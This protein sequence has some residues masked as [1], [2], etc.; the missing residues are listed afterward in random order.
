MSNRIRFRAQAL[1]MAVRTW[2]AG[3]VL[4]GCLPSYDVVDGTTS[5]PNNTNGYY[6]STTGG[7]SNQSAAGGTLGAGMQYVCQGTPQYAC[8]DCGAGA[9]TCSSMAGCAATDGK[10]YTTVDPCAA[11]LVEPECYFNPPADWNCNWAGTYCYTVSCSHLTEADCASAGG[12]KGWSCEWST[13]CSGTVTPCGQLT[14]SQ[15]SNTPG[16]SVVAVAISTSSAGSGGASLTGGVANSP[17]SSSLGGTSS[18]GG[19]AN[20]TETGNMGGT[21]STGGIANSGGNRSTGGATS[22]GGTMGAG[23]ATFMGGSQAIGDAPGTSGS[24]ATGGTTATGGTASG[25]NSACAELVASAQSTQT[26]VLILLDK[27]GSMG[28][29]SGAWDNCATRWNPVVD[30]LNAFFGQAK[31]DGL[32]ASLSFLPADGD[33][34]SA[35]N[36]NSYTKSIALKIPLTR[37]D[38]TGQKT[39]TSRLCDCGSTLSPSSNSCIIPAGGTPTRPAL[40]GTMNYARTV[41][42]QYRGS[43]TVILFLTDGVPGFGSQNSTGAIQN[44]YS[45]DDLTNGCLT[46]SASCE[47]QN[48]EIGAITSLIQSYASGPVPNSIY[49]AGVGTDLKDTTV[50]PDWPNASGNAAIDLRNLDGTTAATNLMK[51]LESIRASSISCEFNVPVP[52]SGTSMDPGKTNVNYVPGSGS[53]SILTRTSDG[54]ALTCTSSATD[55]YFDNPTAPSS[56]QLCPVTCRTLQQDPSGQI[57]ITFGCANT[58]N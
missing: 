10:C 48:D 14:S 19:I 5:R 53:A 26:N 38:V 43:K 25:A 47:T 16:C 15:C 45:C 32:Y 9:C 44:C 17:G 21:L 31:S 30:T 28:Y 42:E 23:G 54:T 2:C 29:Q 1:G 7:Y 20:S 56:I 57:Q 18:T 39:F 6:N 41:Q 12:G 55:W 24:S 4:V 51:A 8:S 58:T 40:Q 36:L 37:L 46:S 50:F 49:I 33:T 35:C 11:N 52:P 3:C 22:F 27:S 34:A 13:I